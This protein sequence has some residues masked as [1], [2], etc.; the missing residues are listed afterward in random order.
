[1]ARG[2]LGGGEPASF[3]VSASLFE[4]TS[5]SGEPYPGAGSL[6]LF[7]K[8]DLEGVGLRVSEVAGTFWKAI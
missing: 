2:V 1:M 4:T 5:G 8:S 6:V 3:S 7:S